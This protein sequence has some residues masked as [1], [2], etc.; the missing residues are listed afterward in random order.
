[1]TDSCRILEFPS[2]M[3][4]ATKKVTEHKPKTLMLVYEYDGLAV[5]MSDP[6]DLEFSKEMLRCALEYLCTF[7]RNNND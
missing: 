2:S 3:Q 4:G 5:T 1:M 6:D 7:P